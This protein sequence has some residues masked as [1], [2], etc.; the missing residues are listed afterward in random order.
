[1]R[2]PCL[3]LSCV[4]LFG[5]ACPEGADPTQPAQAVALPAPPPLELSDAQR[6]RIAEANARDVRATAFED[7]RTFSAAVSR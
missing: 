2:K 5:A 4:L 3:L 6:L 7:A 1:M